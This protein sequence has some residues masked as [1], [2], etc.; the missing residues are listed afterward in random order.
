MG[1]HKDLP[2]SEP[3]PLRLLESVD[4]SIISRDLHGKFTGLVILHGEQIFPEDYN[5]DK[6]GDFEYA[7]HPSSDPDRLDPTGRFLGIW[8]KINEAIADPKGEFID[9]FQFELGQ[10]QTF[11]Y[12][13]NE[14]NPSESI[15]GIISPY[16][17]ADG[18]GRPSYSFVVL[19]TMPTYQLSELLNE[20]R[21]HPE[22][23]ESFFQMTTKGLDDSI[24]RTLTDKIALVNLRQF[25][26]DPEKSHRSEMSPEVI[27]YLSIKKQ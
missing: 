6:K 16:N 9:D 24:N 17:F 4:K 10:S 1:I 15:L 27:E 14:K 23:A 26:K 18:F 8:A 7:L 5:P 2:K 12:I 21:K 25:H 11:A 3:E 22:L 13:E 20:L 19:F